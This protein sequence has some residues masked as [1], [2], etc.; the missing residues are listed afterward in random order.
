MKIPKTWP[1][2]NTLSTARIVT[3]TADIHQ[4]L[5]RS[6]LNWTCCVR[7]GPNPVWTLSF[8]FTCFFSVYRTIMFE[9][10]WSKTNKRP[11][12]TRWSCITK[13]VCVTNNTCRCSIR[14][15]TIECLLKASRKLFINLSACARYGTS[16]CSC[17]L[18]L[19][20]R[21]L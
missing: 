19:L 12:S 6:L 1:K 7:V 17:M 8:L 5:R 2:Q 13:L 10:R 16:Y 3:L 4:M 9:V 14:N 15:T 20:R 21:N 11:T 18:H